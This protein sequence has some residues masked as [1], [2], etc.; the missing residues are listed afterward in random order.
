MSTKMVMTRGVSVLLY[1][2]YMLIASYAFFML[3]GTVGFLSCFIF[4]R[5]IYGAVKVE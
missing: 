4:V 3:T 1:I 5:V 2:G